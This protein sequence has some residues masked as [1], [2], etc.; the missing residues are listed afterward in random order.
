MAKKRRVKQNGRGEHPASLANL[1]PAGPGNQRARKHGAY[2]RY[3]PAEITE[4]VIPGATSPQR[5]EALIELEEA[6]LH[7]ALQE[8]VRW[9]ARCEYGE[10]SAADL[11]LTEMR[12]GSDGKTTKRERPDFERLIDRSMGRIS[13]LIDQKERLSVLPTYVATHIATLLD[14]ADAEG[15]RAIECAELFEREGLAI[16]ISVQQRVR[17]ELAMLEPPEPEG[18]VTDEELERLSA[19]YEAQTAKESVW[20]TERQRQVKDIH[21]QNDRERNAQ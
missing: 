3:H 8:K 14:K 15:M 16:P 4:R 6:R 21:K 20:L 2:A 12:T 18:G 19:E 1:I 9:D 17:A 10:V 11:I 13:A 5:I 7:S